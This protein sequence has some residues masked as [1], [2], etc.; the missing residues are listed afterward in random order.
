MWRKGAET[1]L[2]LCCLI[3]PAFLPSVDRMCREHPDA[4]VVID[5]FARVGI[6]GTIRKEDLDNLCR[7]AKHKNVTVKV[8]AFYALGKKQPPY[9]DLLPMIR[10]VLDAYGPERLMWASDCPFQVEPP[11]TYQPSLDLIRLRCEFLSDSDRE[12]LLRKTAERVFF[13]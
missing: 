4:P 9:V 8:S 5:H 13:A 2:K 6:D 11:H 1:G 12:Q 7:L 10:R 3:D